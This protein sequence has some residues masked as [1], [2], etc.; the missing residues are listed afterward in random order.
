MGGAKT[1]QDLDYDAAVPLYVNRKLFVEF[2]H[3]RVFQREHSNILEDFLYVTFCSLPQFAAMAQANA[4]TDFLI[5]R[6]LRWR[7]GKS[8]KLTNW[9]TPR[10]MGESLDLVEH[11]FMQTQHD[12]KLL[13]DDSLDLL[14]PI[15]C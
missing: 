4:I 3:E 6:P 10:C 2:L 14:K 15:D 11:L 9:L 7:S 1:L 8:C 5:S 12:G 13:M